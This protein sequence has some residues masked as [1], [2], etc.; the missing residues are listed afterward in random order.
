MYQRGVPGQR[1]LEQHFHPAAGILHGVKPRG[2]HARVVEDQ[3]VAGR[4]QSRQVADQAIGV[5]AA[6]A[7]ERE[8]AARRSLGERL[9]GDQGFGKVVMKVGASHGGKCTAMGRAGSGSRDYST[10]KSNSGAC[11]KVAAPGGGGGGAGNGAMDCTGVSHMKSCSGRSGIVTSNVTG[12]RWRSTVTLS[13]SPE[14]YDRRMRSACGPLSGLRPSIACSTSPSSS[15]NA[16][17]FGA[18]TTSTPSETPKYAPSLGVMV[19]SSKPSNSP[20]QK[21]RKCCT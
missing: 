6:G 2:N 19:A 20:G 5:S 3:Q 17:S 11:S 1:P 14:P 4:Q 8:H 7:V 12:L 13:F 16:S 9:L 21:L 18:C 10:T 15:L